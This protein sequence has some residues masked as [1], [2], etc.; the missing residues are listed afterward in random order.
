MNIIFACTYMHNTLDFQGIEVYIAV[1]YIHVVIGLELMLALIFNT[2]THLQVR[3][4]HYSA[5]ILH[6]RN[7]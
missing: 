5:Y 3:T 7:G 4:Q 2:S 6:M 1:T